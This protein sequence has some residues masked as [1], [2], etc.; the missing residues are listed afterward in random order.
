MMCE[1]VGNDSKY[2]RREIRGRRRTGSDVGELRGER[3]GD[4]SVSE[5]DLRNLV[6]LVHVRELVGDSRN[7]ELS[8]GGTV[9]LVGK[10]GKEEKNAPC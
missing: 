7:V 8:D 5:L 10:K 1:T 6:F 9:S 3:S 4:G 2:G